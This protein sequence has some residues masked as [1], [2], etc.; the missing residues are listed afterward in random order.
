MKHILF[1]VL[2]LLFVGWNS[3]S[4]GDGG[5]GGQSGNIVGQNGSAGKVIF[6]YT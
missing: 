5:E 1:I 3:Q 6:Y 2:L 4:G